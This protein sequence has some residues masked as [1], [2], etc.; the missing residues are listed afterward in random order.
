MVTEKA[1]QIKR[2]ICRKSQQILQVASG[3]RMQRVLGIL[4]PFLVIVWPETTDML[5]GS[6]TGHR[7]QHSKPCEVY[8][9]TAS[10]ERRGA[11]LPELHV[12]ITQNGVNRSVPKAPAAAP[13]SDASSNRVRRVG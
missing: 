4:E 13:A 10:R 6:Y 8:H 7:S 2:K 9:D 1:T 12:G 3:L 11:A 5:C